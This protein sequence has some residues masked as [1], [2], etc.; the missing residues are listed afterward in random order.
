MDLA[1][2]NVLVLAIAQGLSVTTTNIGIIN[3]G[4]VGFALSPKQEYATLPLSLQ[5]L[6]LALLLIPV[7]LLMGKFGRKKIFVLGVL[8]SLFGTFIIAFSIFDKNFSLFIIG[9]VL[10]GVSQATQQFYRYAAA[11]NVPNNFK[12]KA[13]SYVLAGGLIAAI[14]GPELS[15]LSYSLIT[16]HIY[17]ATYLI[18][19]AVQILNLFVLAFLQIPKPKKEIKVKR[20]LS[21]ILLKKELILAILSAALGFSLMSFIMTATPIQIVNI[22]K[23]GNDVNA[24]IIQWHV[25]AMFAPSLFTG[26]LINKLGN[27]K[28]M[29]LGVICYLLSIYFGTVG[30][31]EYHFWISLF[32]CGLGWNFLFVGGSDIIAKSTNPREKPIVQGVTDFIIFGSVAFASF[33]GGNLLVTIGWHSMLYLALIPIFILTFYIAFLWIRNFS[34]ST[35]KV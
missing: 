26:Q 23:L 16:Q 14:L 12:S 20:P 4:L 17:L 24:N 33:L 30:Q 13:L 8:S 2:K 5:F 19:G 3:T 15:K 10:I 31:T 28:L 29:S 35:M 18:A 7:S 34:H 27:L 22:C 11:D 21:E 25:I 9:S 1:K 32:L 6:T